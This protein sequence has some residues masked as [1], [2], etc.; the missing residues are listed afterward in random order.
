MDAPIP[1]T[2]PRPRWQRWV[3]M[4]GGFLSLVL[5]VL[6]IVL[7]LLPTTPFVL[8]AAFCFSCGSERCDQWLLSHPRFG[9]LV[10]DWRAHRALS[11]RAK[12]L[13]SAMMALSS[14]VSW[15]LLPAPL[16]WLP[17]AC[18]IGVAIWLWRLPTR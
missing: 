14:V 11:L 7:P 9:P 5:G 8:L 3:W 15:W 17:G 13:A 16:R 4:L 18:C 1:L 6:G 12:Q 2:A 10:R